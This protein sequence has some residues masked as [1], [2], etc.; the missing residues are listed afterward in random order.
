M[1]SLQVKFLNQVDV[2]KIKITGKYTRLQISI[3]FDVF[4]LFMIVVYSKIHHPD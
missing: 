2:M 4:T 3:R 1:R